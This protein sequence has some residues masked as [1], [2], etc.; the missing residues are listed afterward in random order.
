M[1]KALWLWFWCKAEGLNR[2]WS[3]FWVRRLDLVHEVVGV[4]L[5]D[6]LGEHVLRVREVLCRGDTGTNMINGRLSQCRPGLPI[7]VCRR[8]FEQICMN[9][10]EKMSWKEM[11]LEILEKKTICWKFH[12]KCLIHFWRWRPSHKYNRRFTVW[13]MDLSF[14][15]RESVAVQLS[16]LQTEPLKAYDWLCYSFIVGSAR[17][18]LSYPIISLLG[19]FCCSANILSFWHTGSC[20]LF[21]SR[22]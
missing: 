2:T 8:L 21:S 16:S 22:N 15:M 13:E 10:E 1:N 18:S 12:W 17:Q 14:L 6:F 11:F 20:L 19:D 9:Y 5:G 7:W 3:F 4:P